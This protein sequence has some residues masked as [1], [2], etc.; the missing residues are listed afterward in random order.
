MT[1]GRAAAEA[2]VF[3]PRC[4]LRPEEL[5]GLRRRSNLR[6]WLLVAGNWAT[7]AAVLAPLALAPGPLTFLLALL[8][9][10]HG[11]L[12]IPWAFQLPGDTSQS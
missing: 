12:W 3:D 1:V 8:L 2:A 4:H 9:R 6:A 5:A 10:K 7:I 11:I